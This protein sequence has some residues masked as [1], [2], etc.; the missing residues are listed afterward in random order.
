MPGAAF[1]TLPYGV[2]PCDIFTVKSS[3]YYQADFS[4][5]DGILDILLV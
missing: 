4:E 5:F 2:T 3:K 1:Q